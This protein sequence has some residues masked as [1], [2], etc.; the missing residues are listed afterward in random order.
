MLVTWLPVYYPSQL[1]KDDPKLYANNVRRLMASEG[2]LILSDIG[3]AEKRIY[4]AT[5]NEDTT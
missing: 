2:N 4:L 3:L 5:L 1:E